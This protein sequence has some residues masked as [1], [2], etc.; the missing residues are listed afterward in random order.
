MQGGCEFKFYYFDGYGRGE[1]HRILL[2]H[3]KVN[4][5]NVTIPF[6]G[7]S[8]PALK[9]SLNNLSLPILVRPDGCIFN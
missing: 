7:H 2:N 4:F 8:W 5:E 9:P 3:A 1:F 6:D